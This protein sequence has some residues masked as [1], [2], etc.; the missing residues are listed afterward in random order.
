MRL[1]GEKSIVITIAAIQPAKLRVMCEKLFGLLC[2][3]YCQASL[4]PSSLKTLN[5]YVSIPWS[6]ALMLSAVEYP[7]MVPTAVK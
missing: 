5:N 1:Q 4:S 3:Q 6:T 2:I 7:V